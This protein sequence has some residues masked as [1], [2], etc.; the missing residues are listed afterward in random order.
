VLICLCFVI[1]RFP[2]DDNEKE[3]E[4]AEEVAAQL[5]IE[6]QPQNEEREVSHEDVGSAL[7]F[8]LAGGV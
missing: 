8:L 6:G 7:M 5:P 4:E 2:L 1:A 3:K